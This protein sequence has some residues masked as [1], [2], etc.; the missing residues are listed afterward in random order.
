MRQTPDEPCSR[1]LFELGLEAC[2]GPSLGL[3]FVDDLP[4]PEDA[5]VIAGKY[6]VLD[7]IARGGMGVVYRARQDS[8]DRVVA[9]KMMAGGLHATDE[10]KTRFLQ[11]AKAA[12]RL[13]HPNIVAV[14]D[15]GE[16]RSQPFFTMEYVAGRNL[17]EMVA[18]GCLEPQ[19]AAQILRSVAEAIHYA[20]GQGVLHRDLKPSNILLEADQTPKVTDFG[21]SKDLGAGENLT[22]TGQVLGTPGYVPP[23]QVDNSRGAASPASDVYGLGGIL[24]CLITGHPPFSGDSLNDTLRQV[25]EL[26][27]PPPRQWN[28][29]I[30]LDLE[31]ICLKCLAKEPSRRYGSANELADDLSRFLRGEPIRARRTHWTERV[32]LWCRR[33]PRIALPTAA[34]AVLLVVGTA[35]SSGLWYR[36][37]YRQRQLEA[38]AV[39]EAVL[40]AQGLINSGDTYG[41][42]A[43]LAESLLQHPQQRVVGERLINLLLQHD[44]LVPA[45]PVFGAGMRQ[46]V[47]C[48]L[49]CHV[50][51]LGTNQQGHVVELWSSEGHRLHSLTHGNERVLAAAIS[52]D[53]QFVVTGTMSGGRVWEAVSGQFV[54]DLI[55]PGNPVFHL[56]F[57]T[58][59]ESQKSPRIPDESRKLL[60]PAENIRLSADTGVL[61]VATSAKAVLFDVATWQV[62]S[63]FK[64]A[65]SPMRLAVLSS[66]GQHVAAVSRAN[67]LACWET[68]SGQCVFEK[69][70]T[71]TQVVRWLSSSPNGRCLATASADGTARLWDLQSRSNLAVLQHGKAV[72]W[73]DFGGPGQA[74]P[75]TASADTTVVA[76]EPSGTGYLRH[77]LPHPEPVE[78]ARFSADRQTLLTVD[79][80]GMTRLWNIARLW[81]ASQPGRLMVRVGD[82]HRLF[83]LLPEPCLHPSDNRVLA[84]LQEGTIGQLRRMS[85]DRLIQT[86]PAGHTDS[87][88][89]PPVRLKPSSYVNHHEGATMWTDLSPDGRRL[90]TT[91]KDGQVFVTDRLSGDILAGP[92]EHDAVVACVRFSPDG[93]RLA[94]SSSSSSETDES[95]IRVWDSAT[96]IPL[97]DWWRINRPVKR[98]WFSKDGNWIVTS[99]GSSL[100]ICASSGPIPEWLPEVA[101]RIA[102]A[103]EEA[104]VAENAAAFLLIRRQILD[105]KSKDGFTC[106]LREML[107]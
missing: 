94:T 99:V 7:T 1:C 84:V 30:P 85:S 28:P 72:Y 97:T 102:G 92:I 68:R 46:A 44:F 29:A 54:R 14:Y 5:L 35:V 27:P 81:N 100:P 104:S 48:S 15:W 71:H 74:W 64:F 55:P 86:I 39:R 31:T 42:L 66:D 25:L 83:R 59:R 18:A 95:R 57:G 80:L 62:S 32:M 13:K 65:D 82:N 33:N 103:P 24:Y 56:E 52:P 69:P 79:S 61:L 21:L 9:V 36:S 20:H 60:H 105:S 96:G 34:A 88:E 45:S 43:P 91:G 77:V 3:S 8:L 76:W 2:E 98:V 51:A 70:A 101:L 26:D 89:P 58:L 17:G 37:Q 47:Y 49:G 87:P 93:L 40:K 67:D 73:V 16:D 75:V 22:V 63:E 41:A 90:A 10:F 12:A 23:E 4:M 107:R 53:G 11:E 38:S 106:I 19:R 6:R 50:L 78:L